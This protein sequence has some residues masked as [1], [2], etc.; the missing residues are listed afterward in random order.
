MIKKIT[1]F[2]DE[3]NAVMEL[4]VYV[5]PD[6]NMSAT[7]GFIDPFRAANYLDGK[8]HFRW[9]AMGPAMLFHLGAG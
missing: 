1:M 8:S 4:L 5:T 3:Q 6:F 7:V 9:A 2:A